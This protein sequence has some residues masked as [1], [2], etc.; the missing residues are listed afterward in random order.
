MAA[1]PLRLDRIRVQ[2]ARM[3]EIYALLQRDLEEATHLH[4]SPEDRNRLTLAID[5]IE[6]NM[7]QLLGW[8]VTYQEETAHD[9]VEA[10]ELGEI[11]DSVLRW[12]QENGT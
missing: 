5:T 11:L 9:Q 6:A 8:L 7:R 1:P 4:L 10:T 3:V 2:T 12:V